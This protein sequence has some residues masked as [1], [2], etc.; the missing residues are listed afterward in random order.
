MGLVD[1][2]ERLLLDQN[3]NEALADV[4]SW[5]KKIDVFPAEDGEELTDEVREITDD[6][7]VDML[8]AIGGNMPEDDKQLRLQVNKNAE[9]IEQLAL[10]HEGL[11]AVI[12]GA[13]GVTGFV[14]R[15]EKTYD[16]IKDD[17]HEG[18][19]TQNQKWS[20]FE[21]ILMDMVRDIKDDTDKNT[22][23]IS[24]HDLCISDHEKRI[25]AIEDRHKGEDN[26]KKENRDMVKKAVVG[27]ALGG[28]GATGFVI[29]AVKGW[30][31]FGG[32]S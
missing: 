3:I 8:E 4:E 23:D 29:A 24:S 2:A 27:S 7:A 10:K 18:F 13:P 17:I 1:V 30:F 32:G 14:E 31:H 19:S 26:A 5:N 22:G 28:G 25:K 15:M 16:A 9:G 11:S 12:S 21:K 6:E 20:D